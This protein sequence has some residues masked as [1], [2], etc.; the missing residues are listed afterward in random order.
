MRRSSFGWARTRRRIPS[1]PH[2]R[3]AGNGRDGLGEGGGR[4]GLA[5]QSSLVRVVDDA[6][7]SS[8]LSITDACVP[9]PPLLADAWMT[10]GCAP[11]VRTILLSCFEPLAEARGAD[12]VRAPSGPAAQG[13]G[14]PADQRLPRR[15]ARRRQRRGAR[16]EPTKAAHHL[17]P[18][19][20]AGSQRGLVGSDGSVR[21]L[22]AFW[23]LVCCCCLAAGAD[24]E[25]ADFRGAGPT[26]VRCSKR[27]ALLNATCQTRER[28]QRTAGTLP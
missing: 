20:L 7:L 21:P 5:F 16:K 22:G 9:S 12:R 2:V 14:Q 8:R 10:D 3:G 17:T 4:R 28:R 26:D 15:R 6:P 11:I 27:D 19:A 1:S 18:G 23:L 25:F 24:L 13:R